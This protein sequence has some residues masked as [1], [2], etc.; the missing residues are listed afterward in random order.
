MA[1]EYCRGQ[2]Q[3]HPQSRELS[4]KGD[5]YAGI[6]VGIYDAEL[7]VVAVADTYEPNYMEAYISIKYCPICGQA[8]NKEERK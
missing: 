5:F 1:C 8:V 4:S 7:A 6:A 3:L 2:K